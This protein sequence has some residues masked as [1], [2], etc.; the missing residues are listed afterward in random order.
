MSKNTSVMS[1][2]KRLDGSVLRFYEHFRPDEGLREWLKFQ[3]PS[4]QDAWCTAFNLKLGL[5]ENR[6][7]LTVDELIVIEQS[8]YERFESMGVPR[9]LIQPLVAAF[10]YVQDMRAQVEALSA[11]KSGASKKIYS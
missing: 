9:A 2:L 1:E 11:I 7:S 3:H 4:A 8:L 6:D 10:R 5:E